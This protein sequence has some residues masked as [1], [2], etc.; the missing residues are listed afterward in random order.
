VVEA[1]LMKK[2]KERNFKEFLICQNIASKENLV[3]M[4]LQ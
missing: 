2:E 1:I 3:L 4:K